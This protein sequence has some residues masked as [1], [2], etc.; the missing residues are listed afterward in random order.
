MPNETK[1]PGP[2]LGNARADG[3]KV[4][5]GPELHRLCW[6]PAK[7]S[8]AYDLR[9]ACTCS[10]WAPGRVKSEDD[11]R[12]R[13]AIHVRFM[14]TYAGSSFRAFEPPPEAPLKGLKHAGCGGTWEPGKVTAG[15]RVCSRCGAVA[16]P[17][18]EGSSQ[19]AKQPDVPAVITR[20]RAE[21]TAVEQMPP[22]L[23]LIAL[24]ALVRE[25]AVLVQ[26]PDPRREVG[27]G[28]PF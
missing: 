25:A 24:R 19:S 22:S 9:P 20:L 16:K 11:A 5:S 12:A 23:Q 28:A 14:A 8:N 6:L 27:E 7:S 3:E 10:K 17:S 15:V 2:E 13:H 26:L 21:L 1:S 18:T 4:A